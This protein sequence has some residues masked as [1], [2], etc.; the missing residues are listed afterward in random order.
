[1]LLLADSPALSGYIVDY[2]VKYLEAVL[3]FTFI[4]SA[5]DCYR[6]Y[7]RGYGTVA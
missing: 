5:I 1:M 4:T 7:I 6:R 3:S 2:R